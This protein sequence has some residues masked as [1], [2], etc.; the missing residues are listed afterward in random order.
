[1]AVSQGTGGSSRDLVFSILSEDA[2]RKAMGEISSHDG[3]RVERNVFN[4]PPQRQDNKVP[5]YNTATFLI[6]S[7]FDESHFERLFSQVKS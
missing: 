5:V 6:N 4:S 7:G 2:R 1:M 3:V